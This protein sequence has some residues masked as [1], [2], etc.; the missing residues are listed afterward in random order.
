MIGAIG[1][2]VR[3]FDAIRVRK[4]KPVAG[5]TFGLVLTGAA[6]AIATVLPAPNARLPF[7]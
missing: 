4:E 3:D 1:L 6:A 7:G 5:Q 2:G